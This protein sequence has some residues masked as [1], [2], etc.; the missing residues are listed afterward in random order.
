MSNDGLAG[1]V[2][3]FGNL[4]LF[5]TTD[6]LNLLKYWAKLSFCPFKLWVTSNQYSSLHTT[7]KPF[8][9]EMLYISLTKY[10][11][12]EMHWGKISSWTRN[13]PVLSP[14]VRRWIE[15]KQK[16]KLLFYPH[17]S[18]NILFNQ[19]QTVHKW[20]ARP[21]LIFSPFSDALEVRFIIML[22]N[23]TSLNFYH[24]WSVFNC[25]LTFYDTFFKKIS[26]SL[27]EKLKD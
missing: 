4:N 18:N 21:F 11:E 26:F 8:W 13:L 27:N 7:E 12:M 17:L 2:L 5:S 22:Q 3:C 14:I 20:N 1:R 24:Q 25:M 23:T 19:K 6:G 15:K 16:W 10:Q 9:I